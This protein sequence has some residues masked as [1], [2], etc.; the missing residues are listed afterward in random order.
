MTI[1]CYPPLVGDNY[2]LTIHS[3][4]NRPEQRIAADGLAEEI[5][6]AIFQGPIA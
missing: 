4:M 3:G 2:S 1:H 6:R 5:D